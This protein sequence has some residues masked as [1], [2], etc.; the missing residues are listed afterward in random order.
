MQWSVHLYASLLWWI[1]SRTWDLPDVYYWLD[2]WVLKKHQKDFT[3]FICDTLPGLN[4]LLLVLSFYEV[5]VA[6]ILNIFG[7]G[8][9]DFYSVCAI[10][11]YLLRLFANHVFRHYVQYIILNDP[12]ME[13]VLKHHNLFYWWLILYTLH[14]YSYRNHFNKK[15][16][17]GIK[18]PKDFF[19]PEDPIS[20]FIRKLKY[21][22]GSQ[23]KKGYVT[24]PY[25]LFFFLNRRKEAIKFLIF[26]SIKNNQ[27]WFILK[28]NFSTGKIYIQTTDKTL[29]QFKIHKRDLS[30]I[31]NDNSFQ[32]FYNKL[33]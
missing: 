25:L 18:L 20:F 30:L 29:N 22:G 26:I 9:R 2:Y 8:W 4:E 10:T 15:Q 11:L 6:P 5:H 7:N 12:V 33:L 16:T 24:W 21:S 17:T 27:N 1:D 32:F 31:E 13:E 23:L 28:K 3:S 14:S 19:L